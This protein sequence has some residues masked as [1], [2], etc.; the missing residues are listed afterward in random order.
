MLRMNKRGKAITGA[1]IIAMLLAQPTASVFAAKLPGSSYSPVQLEAVQ[2]KEMTYYKTGSASIPADIEWVEDS[3][4]L[5]FL[6]LSV[7]GDVTSVVKDKDGVYWIGTETGLQRVN[8]SEPDTKDIVQYMAGPRYLYGGDDHVTGLASDG[9]GGIWART[10]SGVTHIA[11]PERTMEEKAAIYEDVTASVNDRRGMVSDTKFTFTETNGSFDAIDYNSPT[12]VFTS[13]ATTSDNDGLWTTMYA[14]GEIFR[15]QALQEQYGANA[16]MEEQAEIDEAKATAIRS[17]K[18][19]LFLDYVSGRGNGFP[20]RSYMLTSE[21]SAATVGNSVYGYQ[22][23]NG[24]WFQHFVGPDAVNPNGIIPSMQRD[25][26]EPIGYSLV[27]VTK[28]AE[29]KQGS[30][31]FPSGGTDVMNYNGLGLSQEAIDELNLTRP[32]GQKL[33]IDIKTIVGTEDG[34]PIYQVL[35]VITNATNNQNAAEDKTTGESNKPLFQL[36]VPVYE[37]MPTFFNDLFPESVIVDG[38]IDMNQIVYKADTSSDEVDGHYAMFYTAYK[39]LVGDSTDPEL[40]EMKSIIEEATHRMTELILKDDHYYIEDATGKSTQWS[41]WLAKYFN[42]SIG[43]MEQQAQ[44]ESKVG[45]DENGDDALSYGYEDGPLNA[46]E[47]MAALKV[48]SYITADSFPVD[49]AKYEEAYNQTFEGSY[50]KDEP[51]VNGK[52]YIQ[53]AL[54]YIDRRLVRQATNAYNDNDNMIV[55]PENFGEASTNANATLHNDWTQYINYSD[56]ELGWFP[57]F[58]LVTLEQDEA[59][60]KLIVEAFDQWYSNEVRE[61]NP[62]YTFLYQLAHPD[63]KDVDLQSAVHFMYRLQEYLITFPVQWNRQDVFYIEPGDRDDY[64]QTNIVLAPDE[65]RSQKNN[66][67]PFENDN[68]VEGVN[69]NY[70]Y[71]SGE[72]VAGS[73]F[74]LPYWMGRYFEIIAE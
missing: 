25:D 50:S 71:S 70:N 5:A 19:V 68:Q 49:S 11:M 59:K 43:V 18:A 16:T 52:G 31:L 56:E 34:N 54:D 23:Q 39:Y 69:P 60:H 37:Q 10:A 27:R 45:V 12:G 17:T 8:F 36:T 2:T 41:R 22:S 6:P 53:M 58:I 35:P 63:K 29:K 66:G 67:N 38:H 62:F 42:D 46:L 47:V 24:F 73:I 13:H 14:M 3:T 40:L 15:Y 44:W 61:E 65:R 4:A 64:K 9:E 72:I 32:D 51:Y 48:A 21:A 55:T 28:D 20:A 26:A 30:T 1:M 74:T 33:G 7:I 57:V